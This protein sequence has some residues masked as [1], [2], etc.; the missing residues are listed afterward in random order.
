MPSVRATAGAHAHAHLRRIKLIIHL[1]LYWAAE[2]DRL[3]VRNCV[4][5]AAATVTW[6]GTGNLRAG[7]GRQGD[8]CVRPSDGLGGGERGYG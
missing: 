5:Y 3:V 4:T 2:N 7:G 8:T 6:M 1:K